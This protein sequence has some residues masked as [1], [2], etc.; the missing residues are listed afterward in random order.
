MPAQETSV[1]VALSE[2]HRIESE[3]VATEREQEAERRRK[4]AERLRR[5]QEER[6]E[7]ERHRLRVAEAEARLRVAEEVRAADAVSRAHRM[8][9]ELRVVKAEKAVLTEQFFARPP[10]LDPPDGLAFWRFACGA[11]LVAAVVA[12]IAVFAWPKRE[13]PAPVVVAAA[14]L[15][16]PVDQT[17]LANYIDALQAKIDNLQKQN[18]HLLTRPVVAPRKPAAPP[19]KKPTV[20]LTSSNIDEWEKDPLGGVTLKK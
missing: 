10:A 14:P 19:V 6:A 15:P 20:N 17:P 12:V 18:A 13:L 5:E 7:A 2:L 1:M 11:I 9:E 16:P 8:E 4:E 3:R